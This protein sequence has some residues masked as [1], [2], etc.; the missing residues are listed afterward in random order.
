[1][2]V[3][4]VVGSLFLVGF[5]MGYLGVSVVMQHLQGR[6]VSIGGSYLS[7]GENVIARENLHAE[8]TLALFD[9]E[10]QARRSM[11]APQFP[12]RRQT[13]SGAMRPE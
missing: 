10:A 11:V 6:D 13:A 3:G 4:V 2:V 9:P 12:L 5:R 1:M 8:S 7:T